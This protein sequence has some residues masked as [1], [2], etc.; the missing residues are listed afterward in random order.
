MVWFND[1]VP[2]P[3]PAARAR[4]HGGRDA[5]RDGRAED[6]VAQA[7]TRARLLGRHL[8]LGYATLGRI[9][10]D[11]RYDYG[12]VG[13]RD[14]PR[15]SL[16]RRGPAGSDCREPGVCWRRWRT[17]SAAEPTG[18]PHAEGIREAGRG[19]QRPSTS[20]GFPGMRPCPA[21]PG[22]A[23]AVLLA[24]A[25]GR[26]GRRRHRPYAR[27]A[28]GRRPFAEAWAKVPFFLSGTQS[29]EHRRLR[30]PVGSPRAS[31][32]SLPAATRS[33]RA[34]AGANE[35]LHR[36]VHPEQQ[37]RL[38]E[39]SRS[40]ARRPTRRAFPTRSS[41]TPTGNWVRQEGPR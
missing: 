11:G 17:S 20:R 6:C 30:L 13:K 16:V 37:E 7:W 14:E 18:A 27:D 31:T 29:S 3:D 35:A 36:R 23:A 5:R 41:R 21:Q 19:V 1:P 28:G 33:G 40:R 26:R 39:G 22:L 10:F 8:R 32:L 24:A 12:A 4:A 38:G 2:C 15:V 34:F 9:G 25:A